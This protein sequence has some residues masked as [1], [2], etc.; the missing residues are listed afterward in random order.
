M[1]RNIKWEEK[2]EVK[3]NTL[4]GIITVLKG[5]KTLQKSFMRVPSH[6]QNGTVVCCLVRMWQGELTCANHQAVGSSGTSKSFTLTKNCHLKQSYFSHWSCHHLPVSQYS[7][8]GIFWWEEKNQNPFNS[9]E[10][11]AFPDSLAD[12]YFECANVWSLHLATPVT[13]NRSGFF[14]RDETYVVAGYFRRANQESWIPFYSCSVTQ[15][16]ASAVK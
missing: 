1:L 3:G 10:T 7:Q 16:K 6:W 15:H 14:I 9:P 11:N 4:E 2:T 13:S 8:A 12:R 5:L